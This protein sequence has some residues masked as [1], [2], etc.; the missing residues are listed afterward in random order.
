MLATIVGDS[1]Q[2]P[3]CQNAD[4]EH[5]SLERKV[6]WREPIRQQFRDKGFLVLIAECDQ[7]IVDMAHS[8]LDQLYCLDCGKRSDIDVTTHVHHEDPKG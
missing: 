5:L 6:S 4:L 8:G 7:P 3:H 1:I 2:C